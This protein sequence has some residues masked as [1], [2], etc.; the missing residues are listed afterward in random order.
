MAENF[1]PKTRIELVVN[2]SRVEKVN[3]QNFFL[4]ESHCICQIV[5]L[6]DQLR[7]V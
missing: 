3:S 1:K 5:F 7:N 6:K 2:D 4:E